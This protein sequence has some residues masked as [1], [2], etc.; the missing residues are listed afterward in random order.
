MLSFIMLTK[1][2]HSSCSEDLSYLSSH[3]YDEMF[4]FENPKVIIYFLM[5]SCDFIVD[6]FILVV[7]MPM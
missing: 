4:Q 7:K 6:L 3:L 1:S 2:V 5:T